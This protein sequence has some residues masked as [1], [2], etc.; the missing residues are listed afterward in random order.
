MWCGL[1]PATV[2]VVLLLLLAFVGGLVAAVVIMVAELG[3]DGGGGVDAQVLVGTVLPI[4][5]L[6]IG[7]GCGAAAAFIVRR[8]CVLGNRV[9]TCVGIRSPVP[10][11]TLACACAQALRD[12][13]R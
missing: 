11:T 4:A 3:G 10:V 7:A 9:A 13:G 2:G 12:C 1:T 8:L 6:V 5:F